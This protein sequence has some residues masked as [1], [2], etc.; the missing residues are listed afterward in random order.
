MQ[1]V[2]ASNS[3]AEN[4]RNGTSRMEAI[5]R[6]ADSSSFK[7]MDAK[8][9]IAAKR[10]LFASKTLSIKLSNF[11]KSIPRS[12]P[13]P[14]ARTP[15]ENIKSFFG[16]DEILWVKMIDLFELTENGMFEFNS[17]LLSTSEPVSSCRFIDKSFNKSAIT[18]FAAS[19]LAILHPS[20]GLS[21]MMPNRE[22]PAVVIDAS[23]SKI[24]EIT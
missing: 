10:S 20:G 2:F 8:Q 9:A 4:K 16:F 12:H 6:I 17:Q 5:E 13:I 1:D 7:S 24:D 19:R 18:S 11:F 3:L 21:N 15:G 22:S 14:I 23:I